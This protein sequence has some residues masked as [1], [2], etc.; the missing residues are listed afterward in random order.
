MFKTIGVIQIDTNIKENGIT[1][2]KLVSKYNGDETKN[3]GLTSTE[4]DANF[5]FLRG[6]DIAKGEWDS[7]TNTLTLYK[8]NGSQIKINN[9]DETISLDGTSYD[10]DKG[11]LHLML[12]GKDYPIDG[13][14]VDQYNDRI[15][16]ISNSINDLY[17][18]INCISQ[19][20]SGRTEYVDEEIERINEN[21]LTI[22]D[23]IVSSKV[24]VRINGES[25]V[26]ENNVANIDLSKYETQISEIN[27]NISRLENKIDTYKPLIDIVPLDDDI[28]ISKNEDGSVSL[29]L[30]SFTGG[31]IDI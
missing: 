12:N 21:L 31:I 17:D 27:E 24:D 29:K 8:E 5:Y 28:V 6:N 9:F 19:T 22:G 11:V 16:N 7:T 20:I 30:Q 18:S 10:N 15:E 4:I 25:I 23:L 26:D 14:Y 2:Y 1:Y 3:C 13:F